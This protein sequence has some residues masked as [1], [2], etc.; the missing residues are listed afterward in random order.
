MHVSHAH[1]NLV[2]PPESIRAPKSQAPPQ[3]HIQGLCPV[4]LRMA[5]ANLDFRLAEEKIQGPGLPTGIK[6]QPQG[7][8]VLPESETH[9]QGEGTHRLSP[10]AS[11]L[12]L[13]LFSLSFH[14]HVQFIL[15]KYSLTLSPGARLECSDTTSAHCNLRLPGSSNSPASAFRVA[16]TTGTRHHGQLIFLY[17]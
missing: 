17:F 13:S 9:V 3:T 2:T 11:I 15:I 10:E 1:A 14:K 7:P 16:G 5:N 4:Q 6:E 8:Q 12:I